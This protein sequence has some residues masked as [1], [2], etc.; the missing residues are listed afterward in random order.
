MGFF[1]KPLPEP[2]PHRSSK[3]KMKGTSKSGSSS[4][5]SRKPE[6]VN[7]PKDFGKKK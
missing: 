2:P 1:S 3:A 6:T 7:L 4:L 5:A